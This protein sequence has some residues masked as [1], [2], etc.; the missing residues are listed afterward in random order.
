MTQ[1]IINSIP[2]SQDQGEGEGLQVPASL[3]FPGGST[4]PGIHSST[5]RR[6][7]EDTATSPVTTCSTL[8]PPRAVLSHSFTACRHMPAIRGRSVAVEGSI[9][10]TTGGIFYSEME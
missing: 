7:G 3:T 6:A 10:Q 9:N 4:G 2:V 1:R 5:A 8:T